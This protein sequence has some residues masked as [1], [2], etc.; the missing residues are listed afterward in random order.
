MC[1]EG[2]GSNWAPLMP[3]LPLAIKESRQC[4]SNMATLPPYLRNTWGQAGPS[5]PGAQPGPWSSFLL[6]YQPTNSCPFLYNGRGQSELQS[7]G[8]QWKSVPFAHSSDKPNKQGWDSWTVDPWK[9]KWQ[10]LPSSFKKTLTFICWPHRLQSETHHQ[11][12]ST[13]LCCSSPQVRGCQWD[14]RLAPP[15]HLPRHLLSILPSILSFYK[16]SN[17]F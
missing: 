9:L 13:F 3:S 1:C 10:P 11:W 17:Y 14:R 8:L 7:S 2:P 5:F 15:R 4:L 6:G 16:T 12:T